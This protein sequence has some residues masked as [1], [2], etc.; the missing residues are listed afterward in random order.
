MSSHAAVLTAA[1]TLVDWAHKRR[2]QWTDE[3]LRS[4]A[5]L[6]PIA[7]PEPVAPPE[8]MVVAATVVAAAPVTAIDPI[9]VIDPVVTDPVAVVEPVAA[10]EAMETPAAPVEP[11]FEIIEPIF[12]TVEPTIEIVEDEPPASMF[13]EAPQA[14]VPA[15]QLPHFGDAFDAPA[16]S[17]ETEIP[18]DETPSFD[19]AQ[20]QEDAEVERLPAFVE[21]ADAE[22]VVEPA[23]YVVADAIAES[24]AAIEYSQVQAEVAPI[25]VE[26]E[27]AVASPPRRAAWTAALAGLAQA[28]R[29]C[30]AV[31]WTALSKTGRAAAAALDAVAPWSDAA[32]WVLTR[33]A[34][35]VS[36]VSVAA[37]LTTH[38]ADLFS[39]W[40]R[41]S[42][43]VAAAAAATRPAPPPAVVLP[44]GSGRLLVASSDDNPQV[45][46]DG[47]PHGPAPVSLILP[48]GVH[49]LLLRG[50]K[51]SIERTVRVEAGET[52]D[53]NEQIFPGWLAVSASVDLTF[54]EN[55]R[56]LKR[57]ERGWAMLPPGP[58]DVHLD[59]DALG[60]HETRHIVVTPGDAT[61]VSLAP[62]S[63]TLSVTTNEPAEVWVDG[64]SLG[65]AP[66]VDSPMKLGMHDLRV[67][68]ASHERW[69]RVR[70]T[71]QPT[72]VNVDLTAQ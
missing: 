2:R 13:F 70:V 35:V 15:L 72:Q 30:G 12:E 50:P 34:A 53:L 16:E 23:A 29:A 4:V 67:R 58:H 47:K 33:G 52:A 48:A 41:L 49:R 27:P 8:P 20:Y 56:T 54:S 68:S 10:F 32:L 37:L 42:E 57:D 63:S 25:A 6:E 11:I 71:T 43:T 22:S 46:V 64:A 61:R 17:L 45:I 66:I 14:D 39:R 38:R 40:D 36:I 62:P 7:V 24:P 18:L 28:F 9:A 3:P 5:V 59:N 44:P 55:G 51:G 21:A 19:T 69:L 65:E 31:A 60:I 1:T 26:P